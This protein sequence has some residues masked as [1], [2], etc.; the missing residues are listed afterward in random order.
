VVGGRLGDH[1]TAVSHGGSFCL[2]EAEPVAAAATSETPV[3][4]AAGRPD[5]TAPAG[6]CRAAV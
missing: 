4:A 5:A 3:K 6:V 2:R 1:V